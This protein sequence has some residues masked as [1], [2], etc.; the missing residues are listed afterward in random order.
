MRIILSASMLYLCVAII[1]PS[2]SDI[3][4]WDDKKTKTTINLHEYTIFYVIKDVIVF[5]LCVVFEVPRTFAKFTTGVNDRFIIN[6][7]DEIFSADFLI[8]NKF[9][10]EKLTLFRRSIPNVSKGGFLPNCNSAFA[11]IMQDNYSIL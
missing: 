11:T 4:M 1:T 7:E 9:S 3:H 8:I 2:Q 6:I 10:R 5:H